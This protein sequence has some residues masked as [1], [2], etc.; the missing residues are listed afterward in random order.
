MT[1]MRTGMTAPDT[2]PNGSGFSAMLDRME[3]L[4]LDSVELPFYSLDLLTG[5]KRD[6]LR[7]Q[8]MLGACRDRPFAYSVHLPL[9]INF[10]FDGAAG[11]RQFDIFRETLDLAGETGAVNAV[12][13]T[14]MFRPGLQMPDGE[15]YARQRDAFARAG[16]EAKKRGMVVCVEN[17]FS[18]SGNRTASPSKLAAELAA[19]GHAQV[20]AT[21]DVSHAYLYCAQNKCDFLAEIAALSPHIAHVHMHDSFGIPDDGM[22]FYEKSEA[23][24][25]GAGDLHLCVGKGS[26]PWEGLLKACA[27]PAGALFNIELQDRYFDDEAADCVAAT[28]A[29][30]ARARVA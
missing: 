14:G 10:F 30:A 22:Y 6:A 21:L 7:C 2:N 18:W 1:I 8:R 27:F 20:K 25:Y 19:V 16:D 4:G 28:R 29:I 12:I 5:L 24:A 17:L 3:G 26:I 15:A 23:I 11:Q 9:S 13:H